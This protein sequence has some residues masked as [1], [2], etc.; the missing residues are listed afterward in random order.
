M[1]NVLQAEKNI[2]NSLFQVLS[3]TTGKCQKQRKQR[4]TDKFINSI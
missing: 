2:T 4:V 3:Q 1:E